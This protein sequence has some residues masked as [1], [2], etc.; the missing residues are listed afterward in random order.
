MGTSEWLVVIN[1]ES[2][3]LSGDTLRL[4]RVQPVAIAF[5]DRPLRRARRLMV[6]ELVAAWNQEFGDDPPNAAL[7]WRSS[8]EES[9]VVVRLTEPVLN[10]ESLKFSVT[11]IPTAPET[12]G[13][14]AATHPVAKGTLRQV[15][16]FLD[17]I[18]LGS[19]SNTFAI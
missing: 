2:A 6:S 15:S 11:P 12:P 8:D 5:T 13:G 19:A 14:L 16:L 4:D 10:T 7:S 1:A 18:A 17:S 3:N 9:T